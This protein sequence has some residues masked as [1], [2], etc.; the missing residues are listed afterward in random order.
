MKSIDYLTLYNHEK[1]HCNSN[2]KYQFMNPLVISSAGYSSMLC[3]TYRFVI[4]RYT[5]VTLIMLSGR[6][7][8]IRQSTISTSNTLH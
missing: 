5:S 8:K 1:T 7:V 3:D 4:Y 2:L 6:V